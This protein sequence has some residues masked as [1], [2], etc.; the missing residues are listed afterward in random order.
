MLDGC[1][2]GVL[3]CLIAVGIEVFVYGCVRLLNLCVRG[4]LEVHVQVLSEVPTQVELAVPQE[5]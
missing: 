2:H 1:P 5:L 4:A 3:P